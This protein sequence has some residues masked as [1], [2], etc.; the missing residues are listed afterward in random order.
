MKFGIQQLIATILASMFYVGSVQ[1]VPLYYTFE[2]TV[3][4]WPTYPDTGDS[5]LLEN[6]GLFTGDALSL[7]VMI[8]KDRDRNGNLIEVPEVP[9][10]MYGNIYRNYQAEFVESSVFDLVHS[11][12]PDRSV[13]P[14][15]VYASSEF[16]YRD[17]VLVDDAIFSDVFLSVSSDLIGHHSLYINDADL[18]NWEIGSTASADNYTALHGEQPDEFSAFESYLRLTAIS[19]ENPASGDEGTPYHSVPEPSTFLLTSLGLLGIG[20]RRYFKTT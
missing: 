5:D 12:Y 20:A 11:Y 18:S 2:G 13:E 19:T 4:N 16:V 6:I 7:T 17:G 8:D 15:S 9:E 14:V 10:G 3:T 1:A